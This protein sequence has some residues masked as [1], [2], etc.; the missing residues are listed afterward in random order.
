MPAKNSNAVRD[1]KSVAS[2]LDNLIKDL[3]KKHGVE[4]LSIFG[5][6]QAVV[7]WIPVDSFSVSELLGGGIPRGR[8][9]EV[10]GPESSG[11]A[12][13]LD[14][15]V[16]T[17]EGYKKMGSLS[18][19]DI[20]IDGCGQETTIIGI[21]P[22]DEQEVF[23]VTFNDGSSTRCTRDHLWKILW[24]RWKN[25]KNSSEEVL[26]LQEILGRGLTR[27]ATQRSG[28]KLVFYRARIPVP[29]IHF[30]ERP[31]P[32]DPYLLGVLLGDGSISGNSLSVSLYEEDILNKVSS[33]LRDIGY[34]L[35]RISKNP[36][37]KDYR[38]VSSNTLSGN[39]ASYLGDTTFYSPL[40]QTLLDLRVKELS[41]D[42]RIPPDYLYN[43]V[44]VRIALLQGLFDT[45]GSVSKS[46]LEY[47]TSSSGMSEDFAFLVRSLGGVDTV[48]VRNASYKDKNG[49]RVVCNNTYRHYI[50]LPD[51]VCAFSSQKHSFRW[52]QSR[53]SV[54]RSIRAVDSIGYAPC[55]C[56]RVSSPD[57]TYITDSMIVTHNTTFLTYLAAQIQK[58]YFEDRKRYGVVALIDVEHAFDPEYAKSFGLDMSKVVFSQPDSGEQALDIVYDL[59]DSDQT[60]CILIDSVAAITPQAEIDG[61]MGDM[62]VGLPA[63]LMGKACRRL[64]ARMKPNSAT[65]IFSNQVRSKIGGYS[66]TG[67][68]TDT[69]GG[70]ALKFFSSI[71]VQTKKGDWIGE[72]T[73]SG[74]LQGIHCI[75]RTQKN[76]LASPYRTVDMSII[77]GKGYQLEG[78]Y[79]A[80]FVKYGFIQKA[81]AGWF[82]VVNL[83][84]STRKVQGASNVMAYLKSQEGLLDD[85]KKRLQSVMS[86]RKTVITEKK[87]D[88]GDID[89]VAEEQE[90]LEKEFENTDANKLAAEALVNE[91][92]IDITANDIPDIPEEPA[93][94]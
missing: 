5:E 84:G 8:I 75:L 69:P 34:E 4:A 39:K 54:I 94:R 9:I 57:Q 29:I 21:F 25:G 49:S 15:D 14:C 1:R 70:K 56:I 13:P 50:R 26:S 43:S 17:P 66:P 86:S 44:D 60:D 79:I 16:L 91:E 59:L 83:D 48:S 76:K 78:E 80:G 89:T 73:D 63:R 87:E 42:K 19:G 7:E 3:Q 58:H 62:Q 51:S 41:V 67:E 37:I 72:T 11:K 88:E 38:I 28:K 35:H 65:I 22:Q 12:Q 46:H 47:S 18:V 81:A 6:N 33:I 68:A 85:L 53:V 90:R 55:Q 20:V 93:E 36:T 31:V 61:E 71:R 92:R 77:F 30:K 27:E 40:K 2:S 32:V 64:T 82:T 23:K 45:D 10:F 24:Q 74:G 52:R